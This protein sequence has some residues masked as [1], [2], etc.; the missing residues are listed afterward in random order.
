MDALTDALD[1]GADPSILDGDGL[2]PADVAM[3]TRNQGVYDVLNYYVPTDIENM[4]NKQIYTLVQHQQEQQRLRQRWKRKQGATDE[5][6]DNNNEDKGESDEKTVFKGNIEGQK[7]MLL[8]PA[9]V[10]V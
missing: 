9:V 6:D 8:L 2:T 1:M 3:L 5:D 7:E 10:M 4:R